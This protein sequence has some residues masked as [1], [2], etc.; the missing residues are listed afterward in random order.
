MKKFVTA[1][2]LLVLVAVVL[3]RFRQP[4]ADRAM[5]KCQEMLDRRMPERADPSRQRTEPAAVPAG[6]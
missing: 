4:L 5:E 3:R 2:A 6:R 1:M